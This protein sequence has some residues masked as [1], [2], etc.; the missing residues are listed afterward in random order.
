M[1]SLSMSKLGELEGD[2]PLKPID[3]ES[4]ETTCSEE[5]QHFDRKNVDFS[6]DDI[7]EEAADLQAIR[8]GESMKSLNNT[9]IPYRRASVQLSNSNGHISAH[10]VNKLSTE[11][12]RLEGELSAS[13]ELYNNLL[14]E[15]A[16]AN[17]EILRLLEENDK[18]SE[19]NKQ[20]DELLK[21]VE[22]MQ[23]KLET[24]LQ[25]VSYTHL[26]VYKRQSFCKA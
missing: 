26:D 1:L 7:P 10:L 18:F 3:D 23:R 22:Q 13:K 15:K 8:E 20:K 2:S 6:I 16:K 12:K 25:P 21:R 24:S 17:D 4:H 9:S 11:L 14:K 19:V 5:S